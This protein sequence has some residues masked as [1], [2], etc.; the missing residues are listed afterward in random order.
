MRIFE[1]K[2]HVASKLKKNNMITQRACGKGQEETEI[3]NVT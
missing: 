1:L 2:V 3:M